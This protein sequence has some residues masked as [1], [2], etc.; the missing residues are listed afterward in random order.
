[1]NIRSQTCIGLDG[2]GLAI[3]SAL[4]IGDVQGNTAEDNP[5]LV[6]DVNWFSNQEGLLADPTRLRRDTAAWPD[7]ESLIQD[8]LFERFKQAF[9]IVPNMDSYESRFNEKTSLLDQD[10]FGNFHQQLGRH[11]LLNLHTS[12]SDWWLRQKFN[13][14]ML[15][16]RDNLYGS[17][18]GPFLENYF[19]KRFSS[20]MHIVDI[21]C[22]PGYYSN[23]IAQTGATVLGVDPNKDY[24]K[25]AQIKAA[26]GAS[27]QS[28]PIGEQGGLDE[29]PTASADTVF[30]SDALLFY[31]VSPDPKIKADIEVLFS[32]I[33]RILKPGGM[34][35]SVEPHYFFWL[36]PWLG[37][38][39]H[40][41]T[42]LT[43]YRNRS[44]RVTP[45]FSEF[46]NTFALGGFAVTRMEEMY[47]V[48]KFESTDPRAY[49][50]A[51]EFP[52]GQ[53]FELKSM[54]SN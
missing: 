9:I 51:N 24:I 25:I 22:G 6:W 13:D 5:Y 53:L 16:L 42:V 14:D 19:K 4:C 40:P 7:P 30:I 20:G 39:K 47:P 8:A 33:H 37:D 50:F 35:I 23:L 28:L 36:T 45:T 48:Q 12:P 17:V 1:M 15:S 32:D 18:E 26:K 38:E 52:L 54:G 29:V 2:R 46:I 44:F 21:G 34:F 41:F 43:E 11:L 3:L 10:R 31:F 27:F 49:H